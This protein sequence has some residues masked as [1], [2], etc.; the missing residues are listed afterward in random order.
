METPVEKMLPQVNWEPAPEPDET[1]PLHGLPFATHTGVLELMGH[2]LRCYRLNTG[3]T[4][5]EASDMKRFFG[6]QDEC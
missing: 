2:T 5:I 6:I 1:D 3:E 4:L